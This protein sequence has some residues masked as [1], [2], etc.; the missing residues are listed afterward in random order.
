MMEEVYG[1]TQQLGEGGRFRKYKRGSSR[2]QEKDK[3]RSKKLDMVE[4]KNFRRRELLGKYITKMLY[5]QNDRNFENKYLKRLERNWEKW[6][7][8]DKTI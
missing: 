5:E 2:V 4:E 3:C 6:K 7:G 1:R 8:K